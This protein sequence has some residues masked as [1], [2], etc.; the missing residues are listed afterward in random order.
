M[1]PMSNL[2]SLCIGLL[3]TLELGDAIC[4]FPE[5]ISRY[6]PT[7]APLKTGVARVVS[8]VLTR[9]RDDP[10]FEITVLTCSITYM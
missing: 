3:Q 6:H 5:G 2:I 9:N 10:D 7:I 8:D 1:R 4:L